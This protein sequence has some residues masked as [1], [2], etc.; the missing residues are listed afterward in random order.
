MT[1]QTPIELKVLIVTKDANLRELWEL[2]RDL[3]E[4]VERELPREDVKLEQAP[5]SRT[6]DP[7]VIGAMGV[8]LLPIAMDKL[9]DLI[10]NWVN[11]HNNCTV[12]IDVPIGEGESAKITYHHSVPEEKLA[13]AIESARSLS[14]ASKL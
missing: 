2:R 5:P 6:L 12:T 11:D 3:S 10:V 7:A 13:A 1:D 14:K 9:G 4:K 8:V